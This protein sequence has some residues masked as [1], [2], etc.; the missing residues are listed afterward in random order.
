M[1]PNPIELSLRAG[2]LWF[3]A[4]S[5][6]VRT[7]VLPLQI[8]ARAVSAAYDMMSPTAPTEP[9]PV[10]AP[11]QKQ[12][13]RAARGE[14][15]PGEA[16]QGRRVR[17]DAEARAAQ[18]TDA[19]PAPGAEVHVAEP[20]EGYALMAP[21]DILARLGD[22]DEATRAAVRLYDLAHDAREAVLHATG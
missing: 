11:S 19:L 18:P 1:T 20:W 13:R 21:A 15:T 3:R 4:A 8:S 2:S 6:G 12:R 22:A 10:E 14:P 9:R 7:A 16:A 17:R 5:F